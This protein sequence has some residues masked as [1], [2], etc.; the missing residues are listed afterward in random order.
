MSEL[1]E[2]K[3]MATATMAKFRQMTVQEAAK[4]EHQQVI[5]VQKAKAEVGGRPR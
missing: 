2:S 5:A 3:A 1:V 4:L